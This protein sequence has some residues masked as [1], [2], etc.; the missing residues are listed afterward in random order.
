MMDAPG[1]AATLLQVEPALLRSLNHTMV[2]NYCSV[3]FFM[4]LL[5]D[6]IITLGDEVEY[7]WLHP[8]QTLGKTLFFLNRYL[9]PLDLAI[10]INTYVNFGI[11]RSLCLPW[12]SI[13]NW[14]SAVSLT[15][16][17]I[18]LLLRAYALWN[19]NTHILILL[20][21]MLVL[22]TLATSAAVLY[23]TLE[24]F[25]V[26][27][28]GNVRPCVTAF[29]EVNVVQAVWGSTILFDTTVVILTLIKVVPSIRDSISSNLFQ[30]MYEAGFLCFGIL[31]C[32]STSNLLVFA[33][34]PDELKLTLVTLQ[35]SLF[36]LL[37][38]R[39]TLNLRGDLLK[40]TI[41]GSTINRQAVSEIPPGETLPTNDSQTS[42]SQ[43]T[44][45][46]SFKATS[47]QNYGA[48][49]ACSYHIIAA[50]I[51]RTLDLRSETDDFDDLTVL[52]YRDMPWQD[53]EAQL[54]ENASD[55]RTSGEGYDLAVQ[56]LPASSG[57]TSLRSAPEFGMASL[58]KS[59]GIVLD[60]EA[61]PSAQ[62][63]IPHR[64]AFSV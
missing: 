49:A 50:D 13:D 41:M 19:R 61:G 37:A 52:N 25:F 40:Q 32:A 22:C 47:S 38:S 7:I 39:L 53:G 12:F 15:I 14:L 18:I 5:W 6:I 8:G 10:L 11:D 31:F 1:A 60:L 24:A 33:L 42:R 59:R 55:M 57:R 17:D 2:N 58:G 63:S 16:V 27:M 54:E 29:A 35:R 9:P 4:M 43:P 48:A 34:A 30:T 46:T 36:S 28:P 62:P 20:I 51:G 21:A 45:S 26:E 23:V 56:M 64:R 3:A 44:A